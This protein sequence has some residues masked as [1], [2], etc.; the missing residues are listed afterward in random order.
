MGPRLSPGVKR[1]EFAHLKGEQEEQATDREDGNLAGSVSADIS[2]PVGPE[3]WPRAQGGWIPA[4]QR[5]LLELSW[6]GAQG[7]PTGW[8]SGRRRKTK[9]L[10]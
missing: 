5:R 2:S 1:W 3:E 4:G 6:A 7:R 8:K 9:V 10:R